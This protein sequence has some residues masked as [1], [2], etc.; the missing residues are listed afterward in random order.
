[1]RIST[2]WRGGRARFGGRFSGA[3]SPQSG[4]TR[5]KGFVHRRR[6]RSSHGACRLG[7]CQSAFQANKWHVD[8]DD[9]V[10]AQVRGAAGFVV[11][12]AGSAKVRHRAFDRRQIPPPPPAP[13]AES[14]A[15]AQGQ[16]ALVETLDIPKGWTGAAVY[17]AAT[18]RH[19]PV[20]LAALRGR[21]TKVSGN[22]I[23]VDG[24]WFLL[25][26]WDE[27]SDVERPKIPG[28]PA[29]LYFVNGHERLG[30]RV[31][32]FG[33][34]VGELEN[35]VSRHPQFAKRPEARVSLNESHRISHGADSVQLPLRLGV[36]LPARF[37]M[38]LPERH[39]DGRTLLVRRAAKR[40]HEFRRDPS[41]RH[42]DCRRIDWHV[43]DGRT[44]RGE[45]MYDDDLDDEEDDVF[46]DLW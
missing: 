10:N 4:N 14:L 29:V 32:G 45:T 20:L 38:R 42:A 7:R 46:E 31:I 2:D 44:V 18:C 40:R 22:Y 17:H 41:I 6:R 28:L 35:I 24:C 16:A 34:R 12:N 8:F 13:P 25:V 9:R 27:R 33:N 30:D 5:V 43:S 11:A 37:A 19:C 15:L 39:D 26:D 1:M 3:S 23:L 21:A 36:R